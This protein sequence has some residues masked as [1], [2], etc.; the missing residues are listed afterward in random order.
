MVHTKRIASGYGKKPKWIISQHPGAHPRN[1]SIPL[2]VVIRDLLG[3]ADNAREAK[4]I[5][6]SGEALVNGV[7]RRNAHYGVGLM[8]V[9]AIPKAKR[10]FRA[11]PSRKGLALKEIDEGGSK[12]WLC[13]IKDKTIIRNGKAQLNLHD[14]SNIL[15]DA[16]DAQKYKTNDTL[17]FELPKKKINDCLEFKKGNNAMVVHGRRSGDTGKI[18]DIAGGTITRR[19]L[20][21]LAGTQ[22]P[23]DYVFVIGKQNPVISV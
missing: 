3:Y 23:T 4:K 2:M 19:S 8:D 1:Y 12:L 5:I 14:G 10:Y 7:V 9:I 22:M 17:V 11:M 21:T 6:N 16:K 20:T 13:R 18:E 15:V